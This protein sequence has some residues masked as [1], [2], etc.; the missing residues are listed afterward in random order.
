MLNA[1]DDWNAHWHRCDCGRRYHAAEGCDCAEDDEVEVERLA[2]SRIEYHRA[3][4]DHRPTT[5]KAIT[6]GTIY[7]CDTTRTY[8]EGGPSRTVV[9]KRAVTMCPTCHGSPQ[10]GVPERLRCT[11]EEAS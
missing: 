8:V 7:R 2:W 3:V 1:P 4:K 11:C 5:G 6:P 10:M 9:H